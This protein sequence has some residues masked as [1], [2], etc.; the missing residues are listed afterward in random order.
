MAEGIVI[1]CC[2]L[3][4]LMASQPCP[5]YCFLC[6][7][8]FVNVGLQ[9]VRKDYN[10]KRFGALTCRTPDLVMEGMRG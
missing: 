2:W 10:A 1:S 6:L 5:T 8:K 7:Q 9:R 4:A 3:V